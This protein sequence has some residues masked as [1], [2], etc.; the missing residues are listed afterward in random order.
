MKSDRQVVIRVETPAFDASDCVRRR[1][2]RLF[3]SSLSPAV[4]FASNR[5]FIAFR[6]FLS[7]RRDFLPLF[8][9]PLRSCVFPLCFQMMN[10][11]K[12]RLKEGKVVRKWI[13]FLGFEEVT[14][15]L[16]ERE[17]FWDLSQLS[18]LQEDDFFATLSSCPR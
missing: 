11:K 15:Y 3:G 12:E 18:T 6:R 13:K 9:L 14:K 4:S 7:S 17:S 5:H 1:F 8:S 10:R 2:E 16:E